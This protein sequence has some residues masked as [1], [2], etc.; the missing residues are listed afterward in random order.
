MKNV[1]KHNSIF[2]GTAVLFLL[3]N[4]LLL[5]NSVMLGTDDSIVPH[6]DSDRE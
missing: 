2:K 3:T 5:T 4:T 1:L 6:I